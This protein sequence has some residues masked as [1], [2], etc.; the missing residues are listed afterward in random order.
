MIEESYLAFA[1]ELEKD[2]PAIFLYT[3]SFLYVV[4]EKIKN[5]ELDSLTVSQ[6]RFLSVR[7]WYIETDKVWKI[8]VN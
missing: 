6:D 7:N 3:P 2:I 1:K 5:I 4:P 8:F